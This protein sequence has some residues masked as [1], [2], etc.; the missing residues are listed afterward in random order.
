MGVPDW[1]AMGVP[2]WGLGIV[3]V[4]VY[5]GVMRVGFF[6]LF[7]SLGVLLDGG[8]PAVAEEGQ[9]SHLEAIEL[10]EPRLATVLEHDTQGEIWFDSRSPFDFDVLLN[11]LDS[12][13]ATSTVGHLYLPEHAA[14]D[15]KAPAM[16]LLPG[17]G[18]V[19]LG[20]QM[21]YA[22]L[23][24]RHNYAVL[25]VDYYASRNID[26]DRIPYPIMV[27]NVTEF[28]VVTDAYAALRALNRHPAVDPQ[29]IGVMG[30]SYG[31]MATRLAMDSRV[32]ELLAAD[33]PAFRLHVDFYGPCH[34]DFR[35]TTTTGAPLLTLRGAR[36]ASND[37]SACA[38]QE[39]QLRAAG[40]DVGSV[41][42]ATA[43]HSWGNLGPRSV[44][45]SSYIRG[46][47]V[48]YDE[49]GLPSVHGTAL[50]EAATPID[51]NTRYRLRMDS[52]GFYVG[53]LKTGYIVGR[54]EAVNRAANAQLLGFLSEQL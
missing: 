9:A 26:D 21:L 8:G 1:E 24:L 39:E 31:G 50:I 41:I 53:C 48:E 6:L 49:A 54:N 13:P 4:L 11:H 3:G 15:R 20:R 25:V 47:T 52:G 14:A 30:F 16:V 7:A 22:D 37:L 42:Y 29:R 51:R 18:G 27:T 36:D 32:R 23:L 33:L 19:K 10:P 17:S 12:S 45:N 38:A 35:T 34:Q 2:D 46:C 40:S 43:G 5:H 28:D 44:T